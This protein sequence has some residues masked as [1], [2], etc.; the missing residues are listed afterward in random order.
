VLRPTEQ[1]CKIGARSLERDPFRFHTVTTLTSFNFIIESAAIIP[2][3][4]PVLFRAVSWIAHLSHPNQCPSSRQRLVKKTMASAAPLY[5]NPHPLVVPHPET[6]SASE[7]SDIQT[8]PPPATHHTEAHPREIRAGIPS[9]SIRPRALTTVSTSPLSSPVRRKPLPSTASPLA[10]RYS[11]GEH[12]A[13]TLPPPNETFTRP[14]SVDSPTLYEF[15]QQSSAAFTP[16]RSS[17]YNSPR[18][19]VYPWPAKRRFQ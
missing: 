3:S 18:Q 9:L 17:I 14:Y 6:S 11:S 2:H 16:E 13:S 4:E 15:P 10:T 7:S 8:S 1:S 19:Y 12:L 5:P